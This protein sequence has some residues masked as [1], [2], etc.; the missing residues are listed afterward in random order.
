[1]DIEPFIRNYWNNVARQDE[2]GLRSFFNADAT[3]RWH[4]T[5]EEFTLEEFIRA[6]CDYPGKWSGEVERIVQAGNTLV[7]VTHVWSDDVSCHAT[8]F[9]TLEREKIKT[10]DEYWCDDGSAPQ[11]RL[12]KHIGRPIR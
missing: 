12:D 11:W 5:N 1:M 8:S 10:L 2:A 4:N 9:F 6:N 3:I 7:T